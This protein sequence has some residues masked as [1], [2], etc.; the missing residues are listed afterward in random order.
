[1][2]MKPR[3]GFTLVE[4]LVVIGIIVVLIALLLPAIG[5]VRAR[6]RSS[7]CQANLEQIGLALKVANKARPQPIGSS[8]WVQQ[9][10]P[11][12]DGEV[13][14]LHCPS[15]DDAISASSYGMNNRAAKLLGGD[16][17]KI[18]MLDYDRTEAVVVVSAIDQ[19]D[20]WPA[21]SA[22]RHAGRLNVLFHDGSVDSREPGEIDPRFC[23][24]FID[25]W[26]PMRDFA[27]SL[28]DCL[29][30][31][32]DTGETDAG[33]SVDGSDGSSDGTSGGGNSDGGT[34]GPPTS[35]D[36]NLMAQWK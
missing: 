14:V 32:D 23:Q 8:D 18:V 27:V 12:L 22:P 9:V 31:E 10:T 1:M 4:L 3:F 36:D 13:S 19:Q 33:G 16:S 24:P 34:D 35:C 20:E 17:G 25:F 6:A 30:P 15:D 28:S 26:R 7:H 21:T 29:P 5:V 11:F 2:G